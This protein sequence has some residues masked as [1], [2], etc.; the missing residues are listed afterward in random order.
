MARQG[1]REVRKVCVANKGTSRDY[2]G[3]NITR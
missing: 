2:Y 3:V 1:S